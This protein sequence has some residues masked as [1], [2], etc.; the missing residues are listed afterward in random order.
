MARIQEEIEGT[1]NKLSKE[2]S[3]VS[4]NLGSGSNF[5]ESSN[6]LPKGEYRRESKQN[7]GEG[8]KRSHKGLVKRED[9][10]WNVK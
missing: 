5:F 8:E 6:R 7:N 9:D 2:S 1:H 4:K 10:G 3:K